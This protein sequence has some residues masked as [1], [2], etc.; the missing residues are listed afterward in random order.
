MRKREYGSCE[1]KKQSSAARKALLAFFVLLLAFL[2]LSAAGTPLAF[3]LLFGRRD[4]VP[5][6]EMRLPAD[7]PFEEISF[8][9]G[10]A[11]L[12]GRLY[13]A[14]DACGLVVVCH[15]VG[16]GMDSHLAEILR[17]TEEG[18]AVLSYDGTGTRGSGG[19]GVRGLSQARF[20]L[21]AAL[22]YVQSDPWLRSLPLMLYGHSAGGYA[23]AVCAAEHPEVCRAVSLAAF[24]RP[25]ELMLLQARSRVGFLADLE[26]PFLWLYNSFLFGPDGDASAS[27]RLAVSPCPVLI[28]AG[29]DDTVV[30]YTASLY[31]HVA[32][33]GDPDC[34]RIMLPGGHS[35]FWLTEEALAER[36]LAQEGLDFDPVRCN[37]LNEEL[38]G[39]IC[40]FFAEPVEL[41]N[42]A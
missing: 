20:D 37:E 38:F 42:A 18:F 17:F 33:T 39:E 15:G 5:A 1:G 31:A 2:L 24:D 12:H 29:T 21:E 16:G 25:V 6:T 40:A 13:A 14:P 22:D 26:A 10:K 35:D 3:R 7:V 34:E 4:D 19:S 36:R 23:V 9:S 28:A 41:E 8:Y 27:E 11:L 32:E 30:P